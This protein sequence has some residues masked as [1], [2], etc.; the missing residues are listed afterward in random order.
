VREPV[1][2]ILDGVCAEYIN[3]WWCIQP[4]GSNDWSEYPIEAHASHLFAQE[5]SRVLGVLARKPGRA[6]PRLVPVCES[7][8]WQWRAEPGD[9]KTDASVRADVWAPDV[10]KPS[11]PAGWFIEVKLA[12]VRDGKPKIGRQPW[13]KIVDSFVADVR[14]QLLHAVPNEADAELLGGSTVRCSFVLVVKGAEGGFPALPSA[15]A[16]SATNTAS[17]PPLRTIRD[18]KRAIRDEV[19]GGEKRQ[20]GSERVGRFFQGARAALRNVEGIDDVTVTASELVV[21]DGHQVQV[22]AISWLQSAAT[23][24]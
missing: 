5:T 4:E 24:L 1:K 13:A 15:V 2:S 12:D 20:P 19:R 6:K 22:V 23:Q 9:P 3:S 14:R 10:C 11:A 16:G 17:G 7:R 18:V 8:Y 21:L